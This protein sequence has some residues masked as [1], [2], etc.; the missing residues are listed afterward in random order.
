MK[1]LALLQGM[2]DNNVVA[3]GF[4][5]SLEDLMNLEHFTS[6]LNN[7]GLEMTF[8]NEVG[9]VPWCWANLCDLF[10]LGHDSVIE[11]GNMLSL[12]I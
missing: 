11:P 5:V 8:H 2:F 4:R 6:E 1:E 12:L 3:A 10:A 7:L 9:K